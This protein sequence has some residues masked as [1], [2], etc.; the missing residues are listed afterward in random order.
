MRRIVV[1]VVRH[2]PAHIAVLAACIV[3]AGQVALIR[4]VDIDDR[5]DRR[6][7]APGVAFDFPDLPLLGGELE[8]IDVA[9]LFRCGR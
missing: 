2:L 8:E 1:A 4:L 7:D 9:L 5:I 6:A 3:V